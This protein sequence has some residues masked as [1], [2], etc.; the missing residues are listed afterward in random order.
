M[1]EK[2]S[3]YS[4]PSRNVCKTAR[5]ESTA[6]SVLHVNFNTD[7]EDMSDRKKKYLTAKYGQHQMS[8]IK[9]RLRVEMWM[10]EQLQHL[11]DNNEIE[12]D[13]DE[14]LDMEDCDQ[15]KQWLQVKLVEAKKPK[16]EVDLFISELLEKANIL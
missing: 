3:V 1:S 4:S 8:L 12:I 2:T 14:L 7:K 11:Y 5:N 6:K 15:R 16:A 9:K 10:Y 13:L